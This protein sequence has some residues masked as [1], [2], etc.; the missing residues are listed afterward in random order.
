MEAWKKAMDK[1][2]ICDLPNILRFEIK[3]EKE[4]IL[5]WNRY[6]KNHLPFDEVIFVDDFLIHEDCIDTTTLIEE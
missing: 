2:W 1:K 5:F 4:S 6:N 3:R